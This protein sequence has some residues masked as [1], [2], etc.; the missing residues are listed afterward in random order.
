MRTRL[1]EVVV[2][3]SLLMA[4]VAFAETETTTASAEPAPVVIAPQDIATG[5]EADA[6]QLALQTDDTQGNT[7]RNIKMYPCF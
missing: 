4:P 1:K 6:Q 7:L 3:V 2:V 5:S